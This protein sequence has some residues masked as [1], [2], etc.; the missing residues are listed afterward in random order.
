MKRMKGIGFVTAAVVWSTTAGAAAAPPHHHH[1][2]VS[3]LGGT[4]QGSASAIAQ[5]CEDIPGAGGGHHPGSG[6]PTLS[7]ALPA[8]AVRQLLHTPALR[9]LL[10]IPAA[11]PGRAARGAQR[12]G[13]GTG[14]APM[15]GTSAG[16][17]SSTGA[18]TAALWTPMVLILA[19]LAALLAGIEIVR[20]RRLGRPLG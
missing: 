17:S 15:N 18:D 10:A 5:Y 3:A 12:P 20:R 16:V 13:A 4:C 19:G 1:H 8:K 6:T 7:A 14:F 11:A 2:R 9:A